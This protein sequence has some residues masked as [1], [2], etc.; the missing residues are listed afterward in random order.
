VVAC[1][2]LVVSTLVGSLESA[3][4]SAVAK[5]PYVGAVAPVFGTATKIMIGAA[6]TVVSSAYILKMVDREQMMQRSGATVN[7]TADVKDAEYADA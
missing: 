6:P 4:E 7:E 1:S 2:S 3:V 5:I